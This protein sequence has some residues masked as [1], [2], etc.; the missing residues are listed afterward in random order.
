MELRSFL[1]HFH[2]KYRWLRNNFIF[3]WTKVSQTEIEWTL[4]F[5]RLRAFRKRKM[6]VHSEKSNPARNGKVNGVIWLFSGWRK[7]FMKPFLR[8]HD[9][10]QKRVRG[11]SRRAWE[12]R[13]RVFRG[14]TRGRNDNTPVIE[15]GTIGSVRMCHIQWFCLVW[16]WKPHWEPKLFEDIL[17]TSM[18]SM[19]VVRWSHAS[20][21]SIFFSQWYHW[22]LG[23]TLKR[24]LAMN[25]CRS[26]WE[27]I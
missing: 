20:Q 1:S 14:S 26:C 13:S 22:W 11:P 16:Q 27:C 21:L 15:M 5:L 3:D 25:N 24:Y 9:P 23:R 19:Q 12:T 4:L 8:Q 10:K 18:H 6:V 2:I 7:W 17:S